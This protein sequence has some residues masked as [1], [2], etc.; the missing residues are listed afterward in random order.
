[1]GSVTGTGAATAFLAGITTYTAE[2]VEAI[3]SQSA[4][5]I[6]GD[7]GPCPRCGQGRIVESPKAWGCSRWREGCG[8]TIWR[9][10]A[11]KRLSDKQMAALW[12]GQTTPTIKGFRS[13]AGKPFEA[14][15]TL[16]PATGRV[17][18]VFDARPAS[19]ARQ[20]TG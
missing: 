10:V 19:A 4:Q 18:F 1:M 20:T 14:R 11:G 5:T 2:V 13:K 3:R 15:L 9:G 7:H 6:G 8:Y 17:A 12:A 16:D